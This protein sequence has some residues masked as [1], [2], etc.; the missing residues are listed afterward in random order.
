MMVSY[1]MNCLLGNKQSLTAL[2]PSCQQDRSLLLR[3]GPEYLTALL[4]ALQFLPVLALSLQ[5]CITSRQALHAP[6]FTLFRL[7]QLW[8]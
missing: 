4:S 1:A 7:L 8:Q 5:S 6:D 3:T 2:L